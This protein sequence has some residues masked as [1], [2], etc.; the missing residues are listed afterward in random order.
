MGK[1][2]LFKKETGM[3]L[4]ISYFVLLL[5][6][7]ILISLANI[8]FPE[9]VV[10]GTI[11]LTPVWAGIISMSALS[12]IVTFAVPF[13]RVYEDARS[14]ILTTRDWMLLYFILNFVGVW[15]V[16]RAATQL[17]M[18]ISSWVVALVLAI[19]LD[20]AQGVVMMQIEKMK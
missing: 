17:G 13:V 10:L 5:V 8:F 14:K 1:I 2:N 12:L 15:L 4:V 19:I 3:V 6:N 18:G 7:Y 11:S 9:H 20:T 16:S